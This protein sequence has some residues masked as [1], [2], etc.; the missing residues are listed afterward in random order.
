MGDKEFFVRDISGV[1]QPVFVGSVVVMVSHPYHRMT[2]EFI[3]ANQISPEGVACVA[4]FNELGDLCRD[5]FPLDCL[6]L[7]CNE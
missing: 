1:K 6:S 2:I 4:W 5:E 7:P 3:T